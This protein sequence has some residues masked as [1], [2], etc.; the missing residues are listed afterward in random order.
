MKNTNSSKEQ[1]ID[2]RPLVDYPLNE[3]VIL[4]ISLSVAYQSIK[5]ATPD[6]SE[7]LRY[8]RQWA[9]RVNY[10]IKQQ[11]ENDLPH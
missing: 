3:L 11:Q 9:D 8:V 2:G 7:A 4:Q 10:A 6:A 1:K 5:N